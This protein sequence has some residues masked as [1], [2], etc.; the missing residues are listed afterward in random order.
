MALA[1]RHG[2]RRGLPH[3]LHATVDHF[4]AA[5]PEA[6]QLRRIKQQ[7]APDRKLSNELWRK[8]L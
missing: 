7:V 3:Q 1:L 4:N 2:G 5:Y 8:P 6:D